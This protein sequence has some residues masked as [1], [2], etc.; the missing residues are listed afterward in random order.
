M[1][2]ICLESQ[3]ATSEINSNS[4]I[5]S[6]Y[7]VRPHDVLYEK[8]GEWYISKKESLFILLGWPQ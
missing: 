2:I 5:E 4:L 8:K 7:T 3:L 6:S 1:C